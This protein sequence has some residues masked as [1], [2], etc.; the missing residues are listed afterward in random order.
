MR[1]R[2]SVLYGL[3]HSHG[4]IRSIRLKHA[5]LNRENL[6]RALRPVSLE[7][8]ACERDRWPMIACVPR[9]IARVESERSKLGDHVRPGH[10]ALPA[11][12]GPHAE[13]AR[14]DE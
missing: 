11:H 3:D 9:L 5:S 14:I 6:S 2:G 10:D 1:L 8:D 13:L 7:Y 4:T 12:Q